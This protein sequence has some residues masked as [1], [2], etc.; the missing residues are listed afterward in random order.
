MCYCQICDLCRVYLHLA[1]KG[2]S[3]PVTL[4]RTR[5]REW[6]KGY[7]LPFVKQID[8]PSILY[9]HSG[10]QEGWRLSQQS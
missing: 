10:L 4:I 8:C 2:S 3:A 6:M 5:K 1:G 9:S 7:R